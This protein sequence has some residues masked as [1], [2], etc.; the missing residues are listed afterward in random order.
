MSIE[1]LQHNFI[2]EIKHKVRQAQYEALKVV[3]TQ[4][5]NLYWEIGKSIAEKQSENWGKA[6]VPTLSKE[7]QNEFPGIGG[8]STTNLWLMAQFYAEYNSV[9]FLQ[10]LVGEISWTK[11]IAILNKCKNN[12]ERQF[13]ILSTKKFGW[14]KNILI[15][16]IENKTFEKYLLNQTNFEKTLPENIKNQAHLAIKDEYT[17]DFLNLADEHSENDLEQALIHNIRSFL[18]ELGHNYTFVGNQYKVTASHKEYF[19]DLLLYHR[20][21]QCL[22]AIDL[23]IGEFLPEYKGKMEFYLSVLNDTVKLPHE[24]EAI[25]IIICKSKDRTIVEYSLKSSTLPIGVA[26]Y[27]TSTL[28]P[29]EYQNLLPNSSEISQKINQYFELKI[30]TN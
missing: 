8:F 20:Q 9:E 12:Q 29:K 17:F 21:L 10:P 30:D 18:L 5:I 15:H 24:N 25:G 2:A 14:T 6:I 22:I 28:L 7:L 4:L 13:Y 27:N 23:K 16:Q 3:N 1:I 19:I 26:T 11:Q